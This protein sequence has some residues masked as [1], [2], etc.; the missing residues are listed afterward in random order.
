[1]YKTKDFSDL[2]G[3]KGLSENLLNN[4]FTLYQGYVSNTNK[5]LEE[6]EKAN[7]GS[8]ERAELVRRFGWEWNGMR[9]HELYFGNMTKHASELDKESHLAKLIENTFGSISEWAEDFQSIGAMRG[10]GWVILAYDV[11]S[12]TLFNTWINEHDL[13]HLAGC[14]PVLVMDVFEHAFM[15]DYGLARADYIN[16]FWGAIDWG[17]VSQRVA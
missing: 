5:T 6:I 11:E 4:H 12:E 9:L 8:V 1:M 16:A 10:I 3:L 15:I 14:R 13:G 7:K 2:L 17:V